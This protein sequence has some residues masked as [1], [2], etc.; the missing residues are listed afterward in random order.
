ME[1]V[2]PKNLQMIG[3]RLTSVS[4]YTICWRKQNG[5]SFGSLR[6]AVILY[7]DDTDPSAELH[8]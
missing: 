8:G 4:E 6:V 2:I 3:M 5:R 1:M 7:T